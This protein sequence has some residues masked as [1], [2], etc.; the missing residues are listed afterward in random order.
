MKR[1]RHSAFA[2]LAF[3]GQTKEN[4]EEA[5]CVEGGLEGPDVVGLGVSRVPEA[6]VRSCRDRDRLARSRPEL[7]P[8][9]PERKLARD[10]LEPAHLLGMGV[11]GLPLIARW[12]PTLDPQGLTGPRRDGMAA[13]LGVDEAHS[14]SG[15]L[16]DD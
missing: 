9:D 4:L 12:A 13:L 16:V 15:A 3:V 1:L 8:V 11:V 10:D 2:K 6:M 5:A 7:L 14:L